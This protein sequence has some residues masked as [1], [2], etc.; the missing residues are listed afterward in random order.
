MKIPNLK[1]KK[2]KEINIKIDQERLKQKE[3]YRTAKVK[4]Q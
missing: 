2:T 3:A 1:Q 4:Q